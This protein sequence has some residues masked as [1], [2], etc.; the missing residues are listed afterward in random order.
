MFNKE[1]EKIFCIGRNK[2]GTTSLEVAL[3]EF[4]FKIGNQENAELLIKH[5]A[6]GN[7]A[8][9]IK[10]CK[11]AQAF[12][13]VPFSWPYTWFILYNYFPDAKY[14]LTIRDEEE[15]YKSITTFHSKLFAEG[16]RIP[17]KKDLLNAKYRYKGFLWEANRAVWKTPENDIYNKEM[18]LKNYNTH[19]EIVQHFFMDKP[20]F[21]CIDVSKRDSYCKLAT[22]LNKKP[23]H[24]SFPHYNKTNKVK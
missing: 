19:N 21:L 5:Y 4:G 2:T 18:F 9:I 14:I 20:N 13:D 10:Y 24:K 15:W 6:K 8:P 17:N 7:F 1:K 11:T 12:Q 22:F 23:I 16:K 3:K